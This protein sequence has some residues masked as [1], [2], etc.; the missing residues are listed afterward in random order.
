M[1]KQGGQDISATLATKAAGK[2][3]ELRKTIDTLVSSKEK[4][5]NFFEVQAQTYQGEIKRM[6]KFVQQ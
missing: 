4:D 6:A 5:R 1:S 2:I 3:T